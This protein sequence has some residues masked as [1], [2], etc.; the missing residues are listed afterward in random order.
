ME[1]GSIE[2]LDADSRYR[3]VY[4]EVPSNLRERLQLLAGDLNLVSQPSP[5]RAEK[6]MMAMADSAEPARESIGGFHLYSLPWKTDLKQ[7]QKKQL[8]LFG[9]QQIPVQPL[10]RD[11]AW[12]GGYSSQA[13]KTK[14]ELLLRFA[15]REPALGL[16]LPAGVVRVY[17]QDSRGNAQFLGEDRIGHTAVN[18]E[19]ELRLGK[20]FDVSVQR[21]ITDHD[22]ISKK[23]SNCSLPTSCPAATGP[24]SPP[25]SK[26]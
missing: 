25:R 11:R 21:R 24:C 22:R 20:S 7:N 26:G 10:L 5:R 23:N 9:R 1:D 13:Q 17:G 2:T 4:D 19:L 14:P 18:D 15:N 8:K 6:V 3:I 16:P 12:L